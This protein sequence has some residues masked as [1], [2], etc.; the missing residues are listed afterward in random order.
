MKFASISPDFPL[1]RILTK[2]KKKTKTKQN[3]YPDHL[4][5]KCMASANY[6][7]PQIKDFKTDTT[8]VQIYYSLI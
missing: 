7:N 4:G 3:M 2:F 5:K 1:I 8:Y 6:H